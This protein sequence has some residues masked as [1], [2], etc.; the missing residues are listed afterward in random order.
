MDGCSG[1]D[2]PRRGNACRFC[3]ETTL[4]LQT[5]LNRRPD[6]GSDFDENMLMVKDQYIKLLSSNRTLLNRDAKRLL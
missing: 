4:T 1:K 6:T 5:L 2:D 3:I